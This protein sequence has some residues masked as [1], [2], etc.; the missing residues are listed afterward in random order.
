MA[1]T[2]NFS[3][4]PAADIEQYALTATASYA[5][6]SRWSVRFALGAVIDGVLEADGRR[7][8]IGPGVVLAAGGAR[9]WSRGS[10][11]LVGSLGFSASRT[12]AREEIAGAASAPLSALDVRAGALAGRTFGLVSPY[13]LA[14]AFG[15]PVTWRLDGDDVTGG[16]DHHYQLGAGVSVGPARGWTL[17]LDVAALGER[18]ASLGIARQL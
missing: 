4:G 16:D 5:T 10:W 3:D 11:F 1:S 12:T 15:G 18:G 17:V 6:P 2:I 7:H 13:L 14:R 8:D 9:A